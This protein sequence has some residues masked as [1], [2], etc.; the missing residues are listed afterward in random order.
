M[1]I[2]YIKNNDIKLIQDFEPNEWNIKEHYQFYIDSEFC[3]PIKLVKN[4]KIVSIGSLIIHKDVAWLA[5]IITHPNYRRNGFGTIITKKLVNLSKE[6]NC[7]TIY[8]IATDTG[9]KLYKTLGFVEEVEYLFFKNNT[10]K[11]NFK[12]SENIIHYNK[13]FKNQILELDKNISSENRE[14]HLKKFLNDSFVYYKNN[15]IEGFY[16]PSFG[17]GL[18]LANIPQAGNELLK[19]HIN[20]NDKVVLTEHNLSTIK[21]LKNSGFDQYL[22]GTRMILGLK[23][24]VQYEKIFNRIGGNLG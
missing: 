20:S 24:P 17:E 19:I 14:N 13:R 4:N 15:V 10:K 5:H 18:I 23:R 11:S 8:L 12:I 16:L 1:E 2:E 22:T 3:Y 6:N 9:K 7:S 21:F